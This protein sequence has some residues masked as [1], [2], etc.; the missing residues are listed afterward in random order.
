MPLPGGLPNAQLQDGVLSSTL[1]SPYVGILSL[2]T[3]EW[4][5]W[6]ETPIYR[7]ILPHHVISS[8]IYVDGVRLRASLPTTM[9]RLVGETHELTLLRVALFWAWLL[10]YLRQSVQVCSWYS[11]ALITC[12]RTSAVPT[13]VF[14]WVA[15]WNPAP[16]PILRSSGV[17]T[18]ILRSSGDV[19]DM[20]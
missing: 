4:A 17:F 19:C 9:S 12:T 10:E 6:T 13:C 7:F 20:K 18:L 5:G 3:S 15:L 1:S 8:P 2:S 16:T 11:W 14:T